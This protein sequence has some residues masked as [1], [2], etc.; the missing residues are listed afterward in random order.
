MQDE[1]LK[2]F[3]RLDSTVDRS[4]ET[5]RLMAGW[6]MMVDREMLRHSLRSTIDVG[7]SPSF[8][9]TSTSKTLTQILDEIEKLA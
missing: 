8:M 3:V 7:N 5:A 2:C 4:R 6:L 1:Q 9:P